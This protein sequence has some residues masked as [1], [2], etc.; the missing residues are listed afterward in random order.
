MGAVFKEVIMII[1]TLI[2]LHRESTFARGWP[3]VQGYLKRTENCSE[4]I[5]LQAVLNVHNLSLAGYYEQDRSSLYG[6]G[7]WSGGG[8][9]HRRVIVSCNL[10]C[11]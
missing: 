5:Y 3:D 11:T 6:W 7:D 4:Q 1:S 9:T 2:W 10:R 8:V